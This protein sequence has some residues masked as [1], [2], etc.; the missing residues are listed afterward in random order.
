MEK[1]N[2]T[3]VCKKC[4]EEKDI[5]NFNLCKRIRD[6]YFNLC[7]DCDNKIKR[8]YNLK[9]PENAKERRLKWKLKHPEEDKNYKKAWNQR[10]R[11]YFK[12]YRTENS[13]KIK[14]RLSRWYLKNKEKIN[15]KNSE[16][17]SK[18][19]EVRLAQ[20]KEYRLK[21]PEISEKWRK[22]N[23]EK[24]KKYRKKWYLEHKEERMDYHTE[25][26]KNRRR[27]DPS[28]RLE[29]NYRNQMNSFLKGT[30]KS[31]RTEEVL[32]CSW[33]EWRLYLESKFNNGMAWENYGKGGW[34]VD[35]IIPCASFDH[36]DFNQVLKCFHYTN[37]QP[38]WHLDNVRKGDKIENLS[39]QQL[40]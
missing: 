38:L 34:D 39:D 24:L 7:R 15:K 16:S 37:T 40:P 30:S 17:Y 10:N 27:L 6:G 4:N 20:Q 19:K 35:H 25:Y 29:V 28:Y 33:K 26:K 32:G 2:K 13:D 1:S 8:K 3:K 9:N 31:K 36:T 11:E 21:H 14:D 12:K 23:D 5:N 18:N 22:D